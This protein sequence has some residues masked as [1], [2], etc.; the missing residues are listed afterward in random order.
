[1]YVDGILGSATSAAASASAAAISASNASTSAS[2]ASTS[3]SNAASSANAAAASFDSFDDRYLGAKSSAPSV[4][5]DGNALLTG[6]LYWDSTNGEL[7]VW[8]G[9]AW[10]PA[11]LT[12]GAQTISGVKT[13]SSNPVLSGGTASTALALDASKNVVSVTNTGTG[14]NVLSNSPTLVTPALG[15]P[16]SG[17]VTNLTGTASI[18]I[19]GTVGATT[20]N[21]G[22]FTVL[23]ENAS[24]AVVQ[25]D[26]GS[27]PNEIPLNQ[28]LG[29]LAY[30]DAANIAGPVGVGGALTVVG[31]TTL[32][33]TVGIGTASPSASAILDA[34]STTQG[35]RMPNMTT[36]QKNAIVSPAAGLMV[37]DTTLAKLC[38]YSGAAWETITSL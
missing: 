14:N 7:N 4:D 9:S 27:A 22:N 25:T 30:Q 33:S 21:T 13:F 37:F 11:A 35:V 18:N 19:N 5:N 16:A 24:S 31:E 1:M 23:T 32:T 10:V 20:P 8:S 6:A 15:T 28:Y 12:T 17:V 29:N 36:T 2:N 26:I 3:E 34:Q 38:V